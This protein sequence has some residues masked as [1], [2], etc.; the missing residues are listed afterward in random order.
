MMIYRSQRMTASQEAIARQFC[1][2]LSNSLLA[3][4]WH[5]G[6]RHA[7][8]C[9]SG[10]N[11]LIEV[12]C[13]GTAG[14][15]CCARSRTVLIISLDRKQFYVHDNIAKPVNVSGCK[16]FVMIMILLVFMNVELPISVAQLLGSALQ[17]VH[18]SAVL[19]QQIHV[20]QQYQAK[21]SII[22]TVGGT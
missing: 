9:A 17:S 14:F 10:G 6:A 7:A 4:A 5:M 18:L 16:V 1:I 3:K 22:H 8:S 2:K 15:S 12:V 20:T 19:L 21:D 13:S 11:G